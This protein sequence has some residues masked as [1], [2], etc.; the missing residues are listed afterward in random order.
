MKYQWITKDVKNINSALGINIYLWCVIANKQSQLIFKTYQVP[1]E[2]Y[3]SVK[4][5]SFRI[6]SYKLKVVRVLLNGISFLIGE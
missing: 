1:Q 6:N 2:N 5:L 4:I 3:C